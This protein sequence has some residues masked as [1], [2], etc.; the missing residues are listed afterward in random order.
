[1]NEN[2]AINWV[3][4]VLKTFT[5]GKRRLFGRGSFRPHFVRSVMELL[6]K[7]KIDPVNIPGGAIGHIQV[8][9]VSSNKSIKN[10]L[11]EMYDQWMDEGPHTRTK[12]GNMSGL[13]LKLVVHW[14]LKVWSDHDK[15]IIIK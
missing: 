7:G 3:E 9:D 8:A 10:Q 11:R 6:N 12:E 15:E 4:N 2:T 5:F 1:M 14:I 13:P